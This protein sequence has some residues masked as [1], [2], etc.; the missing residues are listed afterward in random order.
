ME[1]GLHDLRAKVFEAFEQTGLARP[2]EEYWKYSSPLPFHK[3]L[4]NSLGQ[5]GISN[6]GD[7]LKHKDLRLV[8][9]P[10][11]HDQSSGQYT[12]STNNFVQTVGSAA[13]VW[14]SWQQALVEPI[15][16]STDCL[17]ALE[18]SLSLKDGFHRINHLFFDRGG[19][20]RVSKSLRDPLLFE[21]DGSLDFSPVRILVIAEP[22]VEFKI[23]EKHTSNSNYHGFSAPIVQIALKENSQ[24]THLKMIDSLN[25]HLSTSHI[26]MKADSRAHSLHLV[27]GAELVRSH[28]AV[29]QMGVGCEATMNGL[30][31]L[32]NREKADI[33]F[34]A[35]H[36]QSHGVSRQTYKAV[37]KDQSRSIFNGKI[38]IAQGAQ[39]VDS[40]QLN[41]NLL[42][43]AKA[44]A[45]SKPELEVYA[46]DVKAG[47]GSSIGQL[48]EEELFYLLS[49]GIS[50]DQAKAMLTQGYVMDL[51]DRLPD[52]MLQTLSTQFVQALSLENQ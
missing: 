51:I 11:A 47:H 39:K 26:L 9:E 7:S 10:I 49:R 34:Q 23:I 8:G 27:K 50:S 3:W 37:L 32:K 48:N 36:H 1:V 28:L 30:A 6:S 42:L 35:L 16:K 25:L 38:F 20:V 14:Q 21:F 45:N 43:S 40:S 5:K 17:K 24:V 13:L 52:S 31:V 18:Q 33:C 4:E 29:D 12:E 44:E 46:D 41:K 22:G 19:I 2:G 15:E